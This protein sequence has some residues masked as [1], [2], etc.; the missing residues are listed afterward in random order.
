MSSGGGLLQ[1]VAYG[2]ED[3]FLTGNPQITYFKSVFRRHTNFSVESVKQQ[4]SGN[5]TFGEDVIA[6][7]KGGD[8]L[9]RVYLEH[10]AVVQNSTTSDI[11]TN[12]H[13]VERY[14]DSLIRECKLEIG[15]QTIDTQHALW[16]RIYSDLTEFNPSG[17]FGGDFNV[18]GAAS[19]NGTLYQFPLTV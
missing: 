4:F 2:A 8:L 9:Y 15:G 12:I 19:G 14:G 5:P 18:S 3:T 11:N 10:D 16:N 6:K 7:I 17:H 1:L 13:H